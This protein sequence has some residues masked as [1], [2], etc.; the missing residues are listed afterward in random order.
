[1]IDPDFSIVELGIP[2]YKHS[3]YCVFRYLQ[4][5]TVVAVWLYENV[6]TRIE[7]IITGKFA[8]F[9]NINYT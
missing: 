4:N 1:M 8:I 6:N 7:G 9:E 5:R 2:Q 3:H